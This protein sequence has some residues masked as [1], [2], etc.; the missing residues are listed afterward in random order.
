MGHLSTFRESWKATSQEKRLNKRKKVETAF[1]PAALEIM[2]TPPRPIGR[3]VTWV[4]IFATLFAI[5]WAI[6]SKV[7]IV[8][9]AEGRVI[10]RAKL[11]S[12][13]IAESGI[14]RSLLIREGDRVEQ[15]QALIELDP[16]YA[17][18][19]A[20]AARS[21]YSTALLQRARANALLDFADGRRWSLE[22]EAIVPAI[23]A[24]ESQL[25]AAR[26]REHEA[27]LDSL[28]ERLHGADVAQRQARTE[29]ARIRDTLP[30]ARSQLSA[31]RELADQGFAPKIQV[32]ELEERVTT[33]S[34]QLQ[35]QQDEV[36]KAEGEGAMIERDIA[37]LKENFRVNAA[38][39]L[40]EAEA[41]IA[42]RGEMLEK[43][44]RREAL[45]TL[46]APVSGTINEVAITTIGEVAEPGEPLITI[47]PDGDELIVEAFLMN[48]DIGFVQEG[49]EVI[50]KFEAYSFMRYGYLVGEVEH[51]S[52]DA[53]IDQNR[54]LVFPARVKITGSEFRLERLGSARTAG[55]SK[56]ES[57]EQLISPGLSASVEIKTGKR[58][59]MSY[60]LSPVAR[61]TSEA[62]R[63]Q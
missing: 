25:V 59:V 38:S 7:D 33:L 3:L 12:V 30:M 51:V 54:G 24:A 41:V 14:V 42:T 17:D 56:L 20:A 10:P 15:G 43:A 63:E 37:A 61:A 8:A 1:L 16:T 60:L 58:S 22:D 45:Q 34:Y 13:E 11:Q 32:Q 28:Y 18:A 19:D 62:A 6:V 35:V 9:V 29:I 57:Y 4:I 27:Q 5:G 48:K 55:V 26:I 46:R 52:P 44:E 36:S 2:D 31:R 49:Q 50:I 21:E 47:V 39:E 23:A 53:V 40:S